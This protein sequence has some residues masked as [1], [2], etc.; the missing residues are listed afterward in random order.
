MF[1]IKRRLVSSLIAK[2][3]ARSSQCCG[4]LAL[5]HGLMLHIGLIALHLFPLDRIVQ[6]KLCARKI[7]VCKFGPHTVFLREL[8]IPVYIFGMEVWNNGLEPQEK[9]TC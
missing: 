8:N 2:S 7:I 1:A 3:S 9:K 5:S 4:R 6:E